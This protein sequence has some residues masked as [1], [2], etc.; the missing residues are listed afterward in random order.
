MNPNELMAFEEDIA[1]EFNKGNIKAPVHL[2]GGNEL[3]LIDIFKDILPSDYVYSTHRSHYHA[4]LKGIPPELV[5][6]EIMAGHSICLQFPE[7]NFRTS[8]IVAGSIPQAVGAALTGKVTW[9]FLGDMAANTGIFFESVRF[10]EKM[11]LP[12]I[13]IIEDNGKS[14]CTPTSDVWPITS[15]HSSKIRRYEYDNKYPHQG[16]GKR[17]EF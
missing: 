4:L 9:C 14:V 8:A 13:F 3:Q 16:T 1:N 2:V 12:I 10:S 7:Y 17:V 6:K 11:K 15:L 5:K